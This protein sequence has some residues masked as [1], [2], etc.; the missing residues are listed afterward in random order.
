[1]TPKTIRRVLVLP[2]NYDHQQL[3]MVQAFRDVFG[4]HNVEVY[5]YLQKSRDGQSDAEVNAGFVDL[6]Y[7]HKPDWIFMQLQ[8]TQLITAETIRTVKLAHQDA[9]I[10]HWT[11]DYRPVLTPYLATICKACD[12]TMASSRGQLPDFFSA[13]ATHAM[14]CQIGIDWAEDVLGWPNWIP[15]FRVPDVVFIGN[16]YEGGPWAKGS[17]QR[18]QAVRAL[19]EAPGIDFGVVGAGWPT[20]VPVVGTCTVKQQHHVWKRAKVAINV[21]HENDVELYYSDR[22]LIA[23]ASG[24]PVVTRYVPGLQL[25]FEEASDLLWFE[26]DD[27]R[28]LVQ[29]VALLL[30][31]ADLRAR[32]GANGRHTVMRH[33][34]WYARILEILP[35]IEGRE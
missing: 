22:L 33:H 25:E 21:N 2:L 26:N 8:E 11:G 27:G 30:G 9:V 31:D 5:D 3:G 23:L 20:G 18:L 35:S 13:G 7:H 24:T 16:Y 19:H 12:I 17:Q 15:P 29:C 10:T 28:D 4:G 6:A 1:M 34:S 32:I 14:Y